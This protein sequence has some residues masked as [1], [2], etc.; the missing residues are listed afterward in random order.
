MNAAPNSVSE[1]RELGR[2]LLVYWRRWAAVTLLA[3]A[4]AVA[5]ACVAPKTW[6]ASQALIV[7]NEAVGGES[8][9]GR[10][11]A[12]EDLKSIQETD[13]GVVQEP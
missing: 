4:A 5:Y 2:L 7:R 1:P 3:T 6:Q 11:H 10:L 9:P 8:N 12:A 13:H